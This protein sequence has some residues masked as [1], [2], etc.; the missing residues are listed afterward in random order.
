MTRVFYKEANAAIIMC[1]V[2]DN[3]SVEGI[4]K[5][6]KDLDDKIGP[7]FPVVLVVN[8]VTIDDL[9]RLKNYIERFSKNRL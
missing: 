4:L 8:K 7:N 6:K 2:T 5:W 9:R 3:R 1:S